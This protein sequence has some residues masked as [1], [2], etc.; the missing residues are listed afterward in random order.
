MMHSFV[1]NSIFSFYDFCYNIFQKRFG[2]CFTNDDEWLKGDSCFTNETVLSGGYREDKKVSIGSGAYSIKI[3]LRSF[4]L[5]E[6]LSADFV[7]F[8][9]I[10]SIK[11]NKLFNREPI[12]ENTRLERYI[13]NGENK[14]ETEKASGDTTR[15]KKSSPL[16]QRKLLLRNILEMKIPFFLHSFNQTGRY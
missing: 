3:G 11:F 14:T 6:D 15:K 16:F 2:F 4:S 5:N 1:E 9:K 12:D 10:L 13:V 7:K 8:I